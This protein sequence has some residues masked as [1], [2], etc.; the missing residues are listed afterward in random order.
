MRSRSLLAACALLTV[1]FAIGP[2]RA[3]HSDGSYDLPNWYQPNIPRVGGLVTVDVLI[4]PADHGQVYNGYGALG[5]TTSPTDPDPN[6]LLPCTNSYTR[7]MRDSTV[8]W[9]RAIQTMGA[10]WIRNNLILNVYVVGCDTGIP[11]AALTDPEAVVFTDQTKAV[12]LGVAFSTNPCLV[13]NSKFYITSF[14]YNDMY[15]INSQEFGHCLGLDHVVQ[16][17]PANDVMN[18]FYPYNPGSASNPQNCVS[19]LDVLAVQNAFASKFGQPGA[20]ATATISV[21]AYSQ[22]AC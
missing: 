16:D 4:V 22:Q 13:D 9:R 14:T 20:G 6:E 15:N 10:T 11:T 5:G 19:N 18:G 2:V 7:A 8:D 17:H 21:G 12:V 3:S 1:A